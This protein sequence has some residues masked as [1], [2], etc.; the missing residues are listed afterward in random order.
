MGWKNVFGGSDA[1]TTD[2][3][4]R[5]AEANRATEQSHVSRAPEQSTAPSEQ[6]AAV[7]ALLREGKKFDAIK[8]YRVQH[9]VG[10]K[11][12]KDAIDAISAGRAPAV[13]PTRIVVQRD[14]DT[15]LQQGMLFQAIQV[16]RQ[17][18]GT[19]LAVAKDA[20]EARRQQ[21]LG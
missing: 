5:Q 19:S 21:L 4:L 9:Q 15:L 7:Q 2:D 16:Y 20:V 14:I 10:L 3:V 18:H 6:L 12:A 1:S 13:R 11:E 17:R 8:L